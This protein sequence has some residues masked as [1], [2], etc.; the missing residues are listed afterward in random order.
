M[1]QGSMAKGEHQLGLDP[2]SLS[3]ACDPNHSLLHPTSLPS[4]LQPLP[5]SLMFCF[6]GSAALAAHYH[7]TCMQLSLDTCTTL[8]LCFFYSLCLLFAHHLLHHYPL[9][10]YLLCFH[11]ALL[12]FTSTHIVV[13]ALALVIALSPTCI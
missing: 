11:F 1:L 9:T 5:T 7:E 6:S 13:I 2:H 10:S 4:S 8:C 12:L 3:V